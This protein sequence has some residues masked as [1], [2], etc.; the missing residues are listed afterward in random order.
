MWLPLTLHI[1]V[2]GILAV[3]AAY[4]CRAVL[5]VPL[6]VGGIAGVLI[7]ALIMFELRFRPTSI[8]DEY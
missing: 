8:E 4:V 3:F 2:A 5:L 7:Y 1:I 6:W